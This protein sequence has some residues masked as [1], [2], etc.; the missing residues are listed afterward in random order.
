MKAI[1]EGKKQRFDATDERIGIELIR[2]IYQSG[3]TGKEVKFPVIDR[4]EYG[5]ET[6]M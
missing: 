5:K 3:D 4:E 6:R 2:A 1:V